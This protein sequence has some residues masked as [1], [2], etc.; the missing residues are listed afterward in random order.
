[1]LAAAVTAAGGWPTRPTYRSL[2]PVGILAPLGWRR[3]VGHQRAA[4]RVAGPG[5]RRSGHP[6]LSP[7]SASFERTGRA[8]DPTRE[9]P[10]A[11]DRDDPALE[12]A[13]RSLQ[14]PAGADGYLAVGSWPSTSSAR[15]P[16]WSGTLSG[17]GPGPA[18]I[19]ALE[20]GRRGQ[21]QPQVAFA[22]EP[23]SAIAM[24][25][26]ALDA[27]VPAGWVTADETYGPEL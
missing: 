27:E 1:M 7:D 24:L 11:P 19:D 3:S 9:V 13:K 2:M 4:H 22:T 12:G 23:E 14:V 15:W 5:R 10:R 17:S 26:R 18:R 25:T 8:A 20:P 21:H 16:S 6:P